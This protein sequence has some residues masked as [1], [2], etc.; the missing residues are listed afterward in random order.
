MIKQREFGFRFAIFVASVFAA[1]A[2][3]GEIQVSVTIS[4][5]LEEMLPILMQL[6]ESGSQIKLESDDEVR[7]HVHSV[8]SEEGDMHVGQEAE[9]GKAPTA[10]NPAFVEP[11]IVPEAVK[12]GEEITLT[13]KLADPNRVV[14]TL[15]AEV[16]IPKPVT[17]DLFDKGDEGDEVAG[18]NIWTRKLMIPADT[19]VGSYEVRISAFD[20]DGKPIQIVK[21]DGTQAPLMITT[22]VNVNP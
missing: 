13:V 17:V 18:D 20:A 9:E 10:S 4:G 7:V 12:A 14:D 15:S 16:A 5:S 21:P 19:P 6:K 1:V 2:A 11:K 8:T 3:F 22:L